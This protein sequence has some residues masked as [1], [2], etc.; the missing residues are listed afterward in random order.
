MIYVMRTSDGALLIAESPQ[1]L[2]YA[3][4]Q[5]SS[6]EPDAIGVR[7]EKLPPNLDEFAGMPSEPFNDGEQAMLN[8]AMIEERQRLGS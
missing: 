8:A 1:A 7:F 5:L 4:A 3:A 6:E 2:G